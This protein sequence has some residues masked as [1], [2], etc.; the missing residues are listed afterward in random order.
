MN[1]EPKIHIILFYKF[2]QIQSPESFVDSHMDFCVSEGLL[3]KV[4][5]AKEGINGSL[6]GS[7]K[8][9]ERYKRYLT[10][11]EQFSDITLKKK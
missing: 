3:G 5:V 1:A 2:T 6:S 9:I 11:Q 10:D 4:L 7:K 8:Q